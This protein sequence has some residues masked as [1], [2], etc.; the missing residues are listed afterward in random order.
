MNFSNVS[1]NRFLAGAG[2]TQPQPMSTGTT[3]C[4]VIFDGGLVLGA[5]TRATAGK[6]FFH[7]CVFKHNTAISR[8]IYRS[9]CQPSFPHSETNVP[10]QVCGHRWCLSDLMFY[11]VHVLLQKFFPNDTRW[12]QLRPSPLLFQPTQLAIS[13]ILFSLCFKT[14]HLSRSNCC[15]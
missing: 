6:F 5:D 2:L 8:P 11:N 7:K 12:D 13:N 15:G 14:I 1:R 4:G 3:I 10:C 9:R